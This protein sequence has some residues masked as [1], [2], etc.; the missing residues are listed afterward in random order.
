MCVAWFS[1]MI[2]AWFSLL[3]WPGSACL[4]PGS[5]SLC[6]LVCL[7][8]AWFILLAAWFILLDARF[9]PPAASLSSLCLCAGLY[10]CDRAE[11]AHCQVACRRILRTLSTEQEIMEG[12]I[13]Q[14]R[15]QP[16]PQDPMW[17]CFLG[18]AQPP[19]KPH[20]EPLPPAKMDR[21]KLHCCSKA[22]TSLCRYRQ[23]HVSHRER[24][25]LRLSYGFH[26]DGTQ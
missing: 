7:L 10:C 26:V 8:A 12:L 11:D 4:Q 20:E 23:P 19:A 21:A 3:V 13:E 14:C 25:L 24:G 9:S 17:Q 18:S 5:A 15:S 6:G 16:L 1:S 2:V 22:N